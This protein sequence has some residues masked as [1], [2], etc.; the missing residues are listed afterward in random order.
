M[1]AL[2]VALLS[3]CAVNSNGTNTTSAANNS[4]VTAPISNNNCIGST[5]PPAHLQGQLV[6]ITDDA[7]LQQSLGEPEKGKLCQGQVYQ[8]TAP[9]VLYRAWNS[10]NP[11]SELGL[12]WATGEPQGETA[13]YRENYEICYQW[14]PLDKMTQCTIATGTKLV[15][16]NGQS[17]YCSQYLT[18][19]VSEHQQVYLTDAKTATQNCVQAD[20]VFQWQ[21]VQ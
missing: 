6:A 18:Y 7:L 13:R 14:S 19:P 20:A 8:T 17:A 3:G 11:G 15:I 12:W 4:E 1:L 10:T 16:G 21:P 2:S 9:I 5:T